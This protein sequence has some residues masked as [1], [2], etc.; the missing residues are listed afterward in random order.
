[1][2]ARIRNQCAS[3]SAHLWD[4]LAIRVFPSISEGFSRQPKRTYPLGDPFYLKCSA[5]I[6]SACAKV[7]A[8]GENT[9]TAQSAARLRRGHGPGKAAW[10]PVSAPMG[11]VGNQG[12][13]IHFGGL[14][15]A[16]QADISAWGPVLFEMLGGNKF[17]LRQGFRHWRKHLYGAKRRPPEAGTWA[18][19]S[20]LD[21][22]QRTYGISWQS[23][24]SHPFRRAF[25]GP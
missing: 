11:S 13:P 14:F 6:N 4:Q 5:E 3:W 2:A 21:T 24:F 19:K 23:G 20:R 1:M 12:F 16:A 7:F 18:G 9:C 17:R 25:P 15:Q 8:I 10:I 22:S